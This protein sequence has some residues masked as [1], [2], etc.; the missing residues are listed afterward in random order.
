MKHKNKIYC[1]ID[2][3]NLRTA[4]SFIEKISSHIGGIKVRL[5]F[6]MKNGF[7]GVKKISEFDCQFFR[8][9]T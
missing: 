9:E 2:F 6:F 4:L 8:F 3:T 5:E 7:N 1:A